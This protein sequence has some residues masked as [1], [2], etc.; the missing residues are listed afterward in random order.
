[1][2]ENNRLVTVETTTE[3]SMTDGKQET[4]I[5]IRLY[6]EAMT[7][8]LIA[9]LGAERWHTLCVVALHMDEK[10]ECFPTQEYIAKGLGV[11]RTA[12]NRRIKSLVD[13]RWNGKP[14]VTAVKKRHKN[15]TWENTRYTI[16]P[17]SQLAIFKGDVEPLI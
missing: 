4:K 17:I 13:F 6:K 5:F 3:T 12:A 15:G 14:I 9:E 1:M 10:G 11:S 16:L 2:S 8:G 7:A